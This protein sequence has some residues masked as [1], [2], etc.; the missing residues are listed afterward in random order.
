MSINHFLHEA[1]AAKPPPAATCKWGCGY[2]DR[3][4]ELVYTVQQHCALLGW[5]AL[6]MQF[7]YSDDVILERFTLLMRLLTRRGFKTWSLHWREQLWSPTLGEWRET[8]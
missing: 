6:D 4:P 3:N 7:L 5:G 1:L 8:A 2:W